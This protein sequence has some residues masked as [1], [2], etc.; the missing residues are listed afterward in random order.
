M[1]EGPVFTIHI[2][3]LLLA[4]CLLL[5]EILIA[6]M[7]HDKYIRPFGGDFLVVIFLYCLIR[8]ITDLKKLPSS[9]SV[10]A[11]AYL[12][13]TLQYFQFIRILGLDKVRLARV[14]IGTQFSW[15]D[16]IAYT[17]GIAVVISIE[18]KLIPS[19]QWNIL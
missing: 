17:A 16:I 6:S 2:Q 10:L 8:G 13:E 18:N 3:Y 7:I 4:G 14:I 9:I 15:E 1:R 5:T 11:F 19:R 12:I